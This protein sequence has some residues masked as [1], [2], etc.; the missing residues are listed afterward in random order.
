MRVEAGWR[1]L[2]R[3][4]NPRFKPH[5][6]SLTVF[7]ANISSSDCPSS[8]SSHFRVQWSCSWISGIIKAAVIFIQPSPGEGARDQ[9]QKSA[10]ITLR[11]IT[12]VCADTASCA[13]MGEMFLTHSDISHGQLSNKPKMCCKFRLTMIQTSLTKCKIDLWV[14]GFQELQEMNHC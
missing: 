5:S 14:S 6:E 10:H 13:L 4:L 8:S 3:S 12:G 2:A 9:N 11:L 1:S 7:T